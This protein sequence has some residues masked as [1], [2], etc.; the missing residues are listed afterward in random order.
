MNNIMIR[1]L[2][3]LTMFV[4]TVVVTTDRPIETVSI[5]IEVPHTK[6]HPYR[7]WNISY[8]VS[9]EEIYCLALNTY[10]EARGEE[11]DGQFAVADVVM[12]RVNHGKYPDTICGVI[13]KG[14]YPTWS[15]DFPV[16]DKC[17]FSWYCNGKSDEPVDGQAFAAAMYVAETVLNDPKYIPVIEYGLYYHGKEVN[18]YWAEGEVIIADIGNHLFY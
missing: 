15:R 1:L 5:A 13:K 8:P 2:A 7:L 10:F 17:H 16:K 4:I 12:H 6:S 3:L 14:V 9:Q 11:P 18:P